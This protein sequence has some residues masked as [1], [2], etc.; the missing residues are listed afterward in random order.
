MTTPIFQTNHISV[1]RPDR[2][3]RRLAFQRR[4]PAVA[5]ELMRGI[6]GGYGLQVRGSVEVPGGPGRSA[7][8][9]VD[10]SAGKKM[11]K[12]YKETIDLDAI[13]H[14]HSILM[15]LEQ[16]DFPAPRLVM[17]ACGETFIQH[18]GKHYAL[19]DFLEGYFQ[20]HN[21]FYLP[22]RLQQFIAVSGEALGSLHAALRDFTPDGRQPN[23]FRVRGGER[24]REPAWFAQKLEQCRHAAPELR[25]EG[26][27][28]LRRMLSEHANQVEVALRELDARLKLAAPAQLIIHGDYGP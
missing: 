19:F 15:R 22:A 16:L 21:Y 26:A 5:A 23:G 11:L 4:P 6:I 1:P 18:D 20:Y 12:R 13:R 25:A 27:D 14:E 3:Y 7:N 24:W 8:L 17:T 2:L 28:T 9:I 10:T